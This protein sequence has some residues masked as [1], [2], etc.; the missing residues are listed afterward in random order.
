MA[1]SW[2]ELAG[3]PWVKPITMSKTLIVN[4]KPS[5]NTTSMIGRMTGSVTRNSRCQLFAPSSM[6]ASFNSIG[7]SCSALYS[8][9]VK[10][11]IPIQ[12]LQMRLAP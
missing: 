10:N 9:T 1:S 7:T 8:S 3:P 2:V 4:T 5:T 11:G 12:M 6:A